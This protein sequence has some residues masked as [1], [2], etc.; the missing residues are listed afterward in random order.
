MGGCRQAG[1]HLPRIITQ[2]AGRGGGIRTWV[3]QCR[4]KTSSLPAPSRGLGG[5]GG[6]EALRRDTLSP[7]V[8]GFGGSRAQ[9]A[10]VP[11]CHQP[12]LLCPPRY[13]P[14]RD[15]ASAAPSPASTMKSHC[16]TFYRNTSE[17]AVRRVRACTV[18]AQ[19]AS[20]PP[21]PEGLSGPAGPVQR[22]LP[23]APPDR[24]PQELPPSPQRLLLFSLTLLG[25][26]PAASSW[27]G[28]RDEANVHE[29]LPQA[30]PPLPV[31]QEREPQ[32]RWAL[33]A[34]RDSEEP[35]FAPGTPRP[36][37]ATGAEACG[38]LSSPPAHFIFV[39]RFFF[40]GVGIFMN[41]L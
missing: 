24:P 4:S 6:T 7:G 21:L 32:L 18:R 39:F 5:G 33:E 17:P 12:C 13:T 30:I 25:F 36:S 26:Q 27:P 23:P 38:C 19:V 31:I 8:E 3:P 37:P 1:C 9:G 41:Y 20:L 22:L 16:C 35:A 10:G 28:W 14:T 29:A 2:Q 34:R 40:L 11:R 15:T